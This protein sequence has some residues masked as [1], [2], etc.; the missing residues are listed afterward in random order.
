MPM[1]VI[2][3]NKED[4]LIVFVN[5]AFLDLIGYKEEE[6]LGRNCRFLQ[7]LDWAGLVGRQVADLVFVE[8]GD[9]VAC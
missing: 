8:V 5:G 9:D 1:A 4:N 3:P 2:D 7:G 6:V